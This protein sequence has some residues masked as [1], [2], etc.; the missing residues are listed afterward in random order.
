MCGEWCIGYAERVSFGGVRSA[1][2]ADADDARFS[3]IWSAVPAILL[4]RRLGSV[5]VESIPP[6]VPTPIFTGVEAGV[7]EIQPP[8]RNHLKKKAR[9][10]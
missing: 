3:G 10:L 1:P 6:S 4:Q 2:S 8:G 5:S 9:Q 7:A